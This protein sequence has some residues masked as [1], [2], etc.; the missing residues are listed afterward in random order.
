MQNRTKIFFGTMVAVLVMA[1]PLAAEAHP[2]GH[3]GQHA[4]YCDDNGPGRHRGA[5]FQGLTPE[6]QQA[7]TALFEAHQ[8]KMQPLREQLWKKNATLEALSGNPKVEPKE[9]TA[10]VEEIAKLRNQIFTE[11]NEFADRVEKETGIKAPHA[12][13]AGFGGRGRGCVVWQ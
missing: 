5:W 12:M 4:G 2:R 1:A 6:K 8:A 13:G 11:R 3:G 9:I 7:V 10:M